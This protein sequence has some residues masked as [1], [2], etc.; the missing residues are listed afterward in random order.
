MVNKILHQNIIKELDIDALPE[1]EQEEALAA[2]KG[3][4]KT[5]PV[6]QQN[7]D[8]DKTTFII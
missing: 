5:E 1:K 6:K 4:L 3:Q 8:V 2:Q 7:Q